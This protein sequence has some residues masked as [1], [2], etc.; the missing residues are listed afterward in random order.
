MPTQMI[1][2]YHL[3]QMNFGKKQLPRIYLF[4]TFLSFLV[5]NIFVKASYSSF[6][7]NI[8]FNHIQLMVVLYF[9]FFYY[10]TNFEDHF[11][12]TL[13]LF[14]ILLFTFK[15]YYTYTENI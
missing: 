3:L 4:R 10:P 13:L 5:K 14:F 2:I 8:L 6:F 11:R 15:K 9:L 7:Y 1:L 12:V